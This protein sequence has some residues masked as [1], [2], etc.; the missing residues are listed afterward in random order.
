LVR[1][2]E[3]GRF[4]GARGP[5]VVVAGDGVQQLGASAG[6]E[7]RGTV[8]DQSQPEVDVAEQ[9]AFVGGP[10]RRSAAELSH[11]ADV[12]HERRGEQ[13]VVAEPLM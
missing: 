6:L 5:D 9:S 11:A 12:V 13:Q 4:C 2:V 7:R 1:V 8:L 3:H 10:E